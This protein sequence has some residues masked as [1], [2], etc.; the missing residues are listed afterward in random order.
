MIR[1][2]L[3]ADDLEEIAEALDDPETGDRSKLKLMA[4][5]LHS[6]GTPHGHIAKALNVSADTVTNYCKTYLHG[7]I[8]ELI[9]NRHF[10]PTSSADPFLEEILRTL[11]SDPVATAKEAAHRIEQISGIAFS[12]T[13]TRR[14]L[15][16]LGLSYR[17]T[18][19]IPGKVDPQIQFT[20]LEEELLPRL[21]EAREGKRRVFFVDAAH[22]VLG[23]FLGMIWCLTRVFVRTGSG[24]QR[25]SVLGAVETR[26]H[27]L[28]SVRTTGSVNAQTVCQLLD[29]IAH[30]YPGETITLV[31][32]NARY[33]R[34][35]AV[36]E[37]AADLG[38]E[39]LFLPPYSPNLNLIERVWRLVKSRALRNRYFP[40]FATFTLSIDSFIDSL[41]THNRHLLKSLVTEN[42]QSFEI[43]NC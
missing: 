3:D 22:F 8:G 27:D 2:E 23:A 31:M 37:A 42:F 11:E 36:R 25:Y 41:Q 18:A 21:Q 7:G 1:L 20:F 5:R 40:D 34:N 12:Q 26:D 19:A 17:K 16:R 38:I 43:P 32:D 24:R 30:R 33:Q 10:R 4:I 35:A 28:V 39:L 14:I 15:K 29:Q 13:Q 9:E 6:L